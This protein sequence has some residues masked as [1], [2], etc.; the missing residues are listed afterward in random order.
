MFKDILGKP[1]QEQLAI[2]EQY[3]KYYNLHIE[4]F[5]TQL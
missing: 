4:A 2:A 3:R 1:D 5:K